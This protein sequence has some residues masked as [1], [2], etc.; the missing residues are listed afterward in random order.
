MGFQIVNGELAYIG[1]LSF[2]SNI[3]QFFFKKKSVLHNTV[4]D[5]HIAST[6]FTY[7]YFKSLFRRCPDVSYNV[8]LTKTEAAQLH[9]SQNTKF[10]TISTVACLHEN[11]IDYV[12][13]EDKQLKI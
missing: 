2:F 8:H 11:C 10:H 5:F 9:E 3:R 12:L 13:K 7:V 6:L 1:T 4:S